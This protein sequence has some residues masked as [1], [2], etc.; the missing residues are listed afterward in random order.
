MKTLLFKN[1]NYSIAYLSY[2]ILKD[3]PSEYN[4]VFDKNYSIISEDPYF[5]D[6]FWTFTDRFVYTHAIKDRE[7]IILDF[8][9]D[10]T[11][12]N[13]SDYESYIFKK[14][15]NSEPL[16]YHHLSPLPCEK[17]KIDKVIYD[18]N[19]HNFSY[20]LFVPLNLDWRD[21][22]FNKE[23]TDYIKNELSSKVNLI[24]VEPS[25]DLSSLSELFYLTQKCDF[26]I[27]NF[28]IFY[29][30][31]AAIG[32]PTFTNLHAFSVNSQYKN[33]FL[34]DPERNNKYPVLSKELQTDYSVYKSSNYKLLQ[35]NPED[36][37]DAIL[38]FMDCN[39]I[40]YRHKTNQ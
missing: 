33:S 40:P 18:S 8:D 37:L 6:R 3:Q 11:V 26:L 7:V 29:H 20:V 1:T 28:D 12:S 19:H 13:H 27:S 10:F 17:E 30:F 32:I 9:L 4:I 24:T 5:V 21:S 38:K 23:Q 15:E 16:R 25:K 35:Y 31:A 2:C 36:M 39:S 34:W 22:S 14:L